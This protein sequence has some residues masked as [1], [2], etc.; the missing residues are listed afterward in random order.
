[1]N[2]KLILTAFTIFS[3]MSCEKFK[4]S[5]INNDKNNT[6]AVQDDLQKYTKNALETQ[7]AF[8]KVHQKVQNSIVNIR[9]SKNSSN[10]IY[11]LLNGNSESS[12]SLGSGFVVSENGYIVTNYHV[13][14]EADEI[15]VKFSNG[16]EYEAKLVGSSKEV[17]IAVLKIDSNETFTPLNFAN[18]DE[19]KVGQWSIAFGNP[20]GLNDSMTVGVVSA[21]GRSSL[22]IEEIE[23][24]IQ[25]DAAINQGNSGG[26]LIDINGNVIGVNTAIFSQNGGS[27]G[28]GFAIPSNLVKTVKDSIISNG[29]FQR[30]YIGAQISNITD[31][32]LKN[33]H[34]KSTNGIYVAKVVP[35]GPADK[36][37]LKAND[38]ITKINNKEITSA[39]A[40]IGE[41]AAK[42]IGETVNL[43]IIRNNETIK[44]SLQVQS[45]PRQ[46]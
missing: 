24:F 27:V 41:I 17:D 18:S 1:M 30:A 21:A 43:E 12:G 26:P 13:I 39:G 19:I 31:D 8:I 33:L 3:L 45:A 42:K 37:G 40:L 35:N 34:L 23:N 20:L 15:F 25:T 7:D 44:I 11:D 16:K 6:Q 46:Y 22:G 14:N 10:S 9:T 38:I 32:I 36:A 4:N 2:K 5:N 28:I 29:S